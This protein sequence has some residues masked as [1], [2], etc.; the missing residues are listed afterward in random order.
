MSLALVRRLGAFSDRVCAIE[1]RACGLLV[2]VVLG[3]IVLNVFTRAFNIALFWVDELAVYAMIWMALIGASVLIRQRKHIGVTLLA[4]SLSR[5]SRHVLRLIAHILVLFFAGGLVLMSVTWYDP[6]ELARHGF[7]VEAFTG[8]S[9]NFIYKEPTNTLGI[10]KF[11][12]WLSVP[13][14]AT[15]MTLHA[16]VNLCEE[17]F[18]G[19][20]SSC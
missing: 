13:I 12:I 10:Q 2:A 4:D 18:P 7:D 11:W 16:I 17:F 20:S 3:L 8:S 9:F 19:D 15:T 1:R 5:R 14:A 6:V